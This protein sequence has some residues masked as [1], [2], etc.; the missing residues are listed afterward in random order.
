MFVLMI[1]IFLIGYTLIAL[2]HPIKINKTATALMLGVLLWVCAIIG[3]E[4]MLV[5][6]TPMMN[7]L[8]TIRVLASSTGL[9]ISN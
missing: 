3:G 2:E 9:R 8:K 1:V 5:D 4:G 7:T 6:T